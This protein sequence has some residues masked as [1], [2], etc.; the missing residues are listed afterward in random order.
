MRLFPARDTKAPRAPGQLRPVAVPGSLA[1]LKGPRFGVVELPV[2]LFWS[3]PDRTFDLGDRYRAIDM[4]LAVL[5]AARGPGDLAAYLNRDLLIELWPD[6]HLT[7][8]KRRPWED[9]FAALR[10]ASAAA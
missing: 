9:R 2:T 7:R 5:D 4:Y 8:A 6:L 3:R 1:D 10:P